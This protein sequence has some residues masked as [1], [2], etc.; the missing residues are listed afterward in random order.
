MGIGQ[1]ITLLV[2]MIFIIV[3]PGQILIWFGVI[4]TDQQT[5]SVVFITTFFTWPLLEKLANT[6][7]ECF[8]D[9]GD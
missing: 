2:C 1:G 7:F 5:I 9:V 3:I 8:K 6:V 4:T